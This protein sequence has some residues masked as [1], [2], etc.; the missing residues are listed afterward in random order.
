MIYPLLLTITSL[1]FTFITRRDLKMGI[2][3]ILATL[4]SYLLRFHVGPVP[5]TLLEVF[6]LIVIV[7]FVFA[8]N[9]MTKQSLVGLLRSARKDTVMIP[10]AL[11]LLAAT[12]G[13]VVS[14]DHTATLGV[15][16]AYFIEPFLF[17]LVVRSTIKKDDIES[18]LK[19]LA[20]GGLIVSIIAIAQWITRLG[21]PAPWDI[22]RRVTSLFDFPNAVG[23]YLGP[24]VTIAVMCLCE[25][26]KR[27]KQSRVF[28]LLVALLGTLAIIA[29]QT[30]AAYVA[31]PGSLLLVSFLNP[32]ARRWTI[33][34]T[35][36]GLITAFS[37]APIR[38]KLTLHDYSGEVR[39]TQW[40][41][42][43]AMLKDHPLFGA[44]LAGY[45]QTF[46]PYHKAEWVEIFQYPHN[47]ILNIWTEL[48][49][50]GL[51][52]F[53]LLAWQVIRLAFPLSKGELK[54]VGG[55]ILLAALLEM[56]IHGLVDVPFFKN[57]LALMT[58]ALIALLL[59]STDRSQRT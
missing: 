50:L 45:E 36:L 34:I 7:R 16:K 21:I 20:I 58:F 26:A 5:M 28:W 6:V 40:T 42:T 13:I 47:L 44:G 30:E 14:P 55:T 48:G 27:T 52:A 38:Q 29:A 2:F 23:L 1:I 51:L 17:F 22:E 59:V 49:L 18:A 9:A 11:L 10:L 53:F 12:I 56:T 54:G 25:G 24:I 46:A 4:P 31:I 43:I 33:P 15:W 41:E 19:A 35:I 3:F 39:R 37:I 32:R 8:R 57:D